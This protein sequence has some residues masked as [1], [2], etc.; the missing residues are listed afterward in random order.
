MGKIVKT[1]EVE[2][3][4]ELGPHWMNTFN[5]VMCLNTDEHCGER[6]IERVRDIGPQA[7]AQDGWTATNGFDVPRV[8]QGV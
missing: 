7:G 5:L 8:S 3:D 2:W 4:D 6:L 1:F